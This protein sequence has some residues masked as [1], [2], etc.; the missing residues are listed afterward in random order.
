MRNKAQRRE[1][2][3]AVL[4]FYFEILDDVSSGGS[5]SSFCTGSHELYSW[6]LLGATPPASNGGGVVGASC[7]KKAEEEGQLR[8]L[9]PNNMRKWNMC[10]MHSF[11]GN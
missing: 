8:Q 1:V 2:V 6:S 3:G 4:C 9:D 10:R 5:A 11:L 7:Q